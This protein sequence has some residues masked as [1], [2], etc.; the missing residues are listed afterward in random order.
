MSGTSVFRVLECSVIGRCR[1]LETVSA[2][3]T[4]TAVPCFVS[5]EV[6]SSAIGLSQIFIPTVRFVFAFGVFWES[7]SLRKSVAPLREG[8]RNEIRLTSS[9]FHHPAADLAAVTSTPIGS[10]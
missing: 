2:P 6:G 4:L 7:G 5:V 1:S 10:S 8:L 3:Q 9:W